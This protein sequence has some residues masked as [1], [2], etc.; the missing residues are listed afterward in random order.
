MTSSS[1]SIVDQIQND[2]NLNR[3]RFIELAKGIEELFPSKTEEL[4]FIPYCKEGNIISP[5]RGKLYDKFCNIKKDIT[6]ISGT[7]RE[8]SDGNK[9][10]N[11]NDLN[12]EGMKHN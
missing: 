6:K 5:N 7:K 10:F 4:Y 1:S 11:L 2:E 12:D 9:E 3:T 8:H